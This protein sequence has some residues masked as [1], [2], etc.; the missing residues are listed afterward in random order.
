MINKELIE[1]LKKFDGNQT[2]YINDCDYGVIPLKSV[3]SKNDEII[4]SVDDE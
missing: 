4:L 2:V 3:S 1:E